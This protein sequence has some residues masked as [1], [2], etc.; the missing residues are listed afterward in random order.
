LGLSAL[1]FSPNRID[2][3]AHPTAVSYTITNYGPA[4]L[5]A[6]PIVVS[7]Y[8]SKDAVFGNA[9][10][11][12]IGKD[13]FDN[14]FNIL[15]GAA[16]AKALTAY[17]DSLITVPTTV[18]EGDYYVFARVQLDTDTT[19]GDPNSSNDVTR[20]SGRIH[21]HG[22]P[23]AA[24]FYD[25][26]VASAKAHPTPAIVSLANF[27]ASH[28]GEEPY[29]YPDQ[30]QIPTIGYGFNLTT[31]DAKATID[32]VLGN[33][34]FAS[35]MASFA[36]TESEWK[37]EFGKNAA[38][39]PTFYYGSV[40]WNMFFKKYRNEL[41]ANEIAP[42]AATSLL[43]DILPS[44]SSEARSLL[45]AGAFTMLS[46]AAQIA[47]T[48]IV[49]N[50]GAGNVKTYMQPLLNDVADGDYAMAAWDLMNSKTSSGSV[51]AIAVGATRSEDDLRYLVWSHEGELVE[52]T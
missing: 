4:D 47:L 29:V 25:T 22:E 26:A 36:K 9:D 12:A 16:Y 49:Y 39:D 17:G 2:A 24:A 13:P 21:V 6:S 48:D 38:T 46:N 35:L 33:G 50:R 43:M 3:G 42:A 5:N 34:T 52:F 10:D 18:P 20:S 41:E 37:V 14:E 19:L 45:P 7:L 44:Y 8:L 15:S 27:I 23:A 31:T 32:T 51:W 11:I 1:S 40:H 28:E 30:S